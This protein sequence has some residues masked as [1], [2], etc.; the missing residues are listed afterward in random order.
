MMK[1]MLR[2]NATAAEILKVNNHTV[3]DPSTHTNLHTHIL[4]L[5]V[6]MCVSCVSCVCVSRRDP[7]T[8]GGG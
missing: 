5:S 3:A 4:S 6:Y 1:D 2:F 8:P 7:R